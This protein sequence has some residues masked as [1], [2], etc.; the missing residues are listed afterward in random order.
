MEL[1]WAPCNSWDQLGSHEARDKIPSVALGSQDT[2]TSGI[3]MAGITEFR[4]ISNWGQ[5]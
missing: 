5:L 2:G 1:L 3:F 4:S